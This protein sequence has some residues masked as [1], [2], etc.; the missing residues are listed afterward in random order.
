[1]RTMRD[2]DMDTD[3]LVRTRSGLVRGVV[4]DGVRTWRGM[5]YAAPPVG[6]LRFRAPQAP[7]SWDGV[8]DAGRYGALPMQKRGFAAIGG[9]G[10]RTP[11]AEDCLTINV[12][13][14]RDIGAGGKPV[15]VWI[16][17]GGFSLGGSA[18][19]LYRGRHLVERGDV[20]FVSFNYRVGVFGFLDFSDWSTADHP[21]D[22]N[23]GLRDQIA[24]LAW[25]RDNIRAFGGDPDRVTIVGQSAGAMSVATLMCVPA[26]RGLFHRA[27]AMSTAGLCAHTPE[28]HRLFARRILNMLGIDPDRHAAVAPALRQLPAERLNAV[29]ARFFYD[30]A[31]EAYPGFLPSAP[32]IDGDILPRHPID[33]F[34]GG[35]AHRLPLVIGTMAREGAVLDKALPVLATRVTRLEAMFADADPALRTRIAA[36][37]PG[38]PSARTAIDVGGDLNFWLPTLLIAEGH[39]RYADC[40]VYRFDYATPLTRLC[41]REATHGLDLP[42]LFGTTGEGALGML[43]LLRKAQSSRV[44]DRYQR[45]FLDFAHG[46]GPGWDRYDAARRPTHVFD[47]QDRMEDAPREERRLAWG[48]YRGP[49]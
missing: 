10:A 12:S 2:H 26:A 8:R 38:Y 36:A 33:A 32:V 16:Y 24:A 5:P 6:A 9:A 22:S 3:L 11:M 35:T 13:A 27:F 23:P 43:D 4:E 25:V 1:M 44:S 7:A 42:M 29:A 20:V 21:V 45:C 49:G 19:P 15:V 28:R 47:G 46:H 40:W 30:I 18:S 31:P 41:F 39:A 37:Y 34:R 14:P 17:G 48:D